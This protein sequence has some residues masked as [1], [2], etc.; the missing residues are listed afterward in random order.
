MG[1]HR[2]FFENP[3]D[4]KLKWIDGAGRPFEKRRQ[5]GRHK[6]MPCNGAYEQVQINHYPVRSMETYLTKAIKGNFYSN[7]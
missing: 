3:D 7:S 5:R 1:N 4:T 6:G 2:P